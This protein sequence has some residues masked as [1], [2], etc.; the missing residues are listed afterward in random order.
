MKDNP[1]AYIIAGANG[2]GKSTSY[3]G[4]IPVGCPFINADEISRKLKESVNDDRNI[5]EIANREAVQK[6]TVYLSQRENFSF[7]TNLADADTWG[8]IRTIKTTGYAVIVIYLGV[9]DVE[10]C[11]Q[12]VKQ[13]VK[14]G[15]HNVREDV[16]RARCQ[17]SMALLTRNLS[18]PDRLI[19]IDTTSS[20]PQVGAVLSEGNIVDKNDRLPKW[21]NVCLA[22][23][24]SDKNTQISSIEEARKKYEELKKRMKPE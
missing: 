22:S 4:Y 6:M 21:I 15:G 19:L 18:I 20:Q 16:I 7:E 8:F 5:Q 17:A 14:E 24:S 12:R 10:I 9:E 3:Y 23:V 2:V 13:R 1:V 11:I